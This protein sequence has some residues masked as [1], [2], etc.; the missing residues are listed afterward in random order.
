MLCSGNTIDIMEPIEI[1]NKKFVMSCP[2][3]GTCVLDGR[4][5]V[6]IMYT[7]DDYDFIFDGV[8]FANANNWDVS[9]ILV[10]SISF[11]SIFSSSIFF[12]IVLRVSPIF[13][14]PSV[15]GYSGGS[16]MQMN[17][18]TYGYFPKATFRKCQFR[19][20]VGGLVCHSLPCF[21][22]TLIASILTFIL[23]L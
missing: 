17:F 9:I 21:A 18:P 6:E 13:L 15:K 23:C 22:Q 19:G 14:H 16:A 1:W 8:T 7:V 11:L 20:N 5:L 2:D 10:A 3:H 12:H 4:N